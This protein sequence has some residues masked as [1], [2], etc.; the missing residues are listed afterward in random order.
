MERTDRTR[1]HPKTGLTSGLPDVG[2]D[3]WDA[4]ALFSALGPDFSQTV[5]WAHR[6]GRYADIAYAHDHAL[7]RSVEIHSSW[8][9]FEW[10]AADA[11]QQGYRVGI[12]G[13]SDGHKGRPGS[14]PPGLSASLGCASHSKISVCSTTRVRGRLFVDDRRLRL[15]RLPNF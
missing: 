9:T 3:C 1:Q 10:L 15:S 7:E 6:G 14:E 4:R 12:V 2:T 8:G 11:F 5:V 13:N